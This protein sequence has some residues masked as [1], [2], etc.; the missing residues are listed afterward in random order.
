M[1]SWFRG[2]KTN[3]EKSF[4]IRC[5]T[6]FRSMIEEQHKFSDCDRFE[7]FVTQNTSEKIFH[8]T[9]HINYCSIIQ[10]GYIKGGINE[11]STWGTDSSFFCNLGCVCLINNKS[12]YRVDLS[13]EEGL[14]YY[15]KFPFAD[16][17]FISRYCKDKVV[18]LIL[19]DEISQDLISWQTWKDEEKLRERVV[20]YY[21]AGYKGNLPLSLVEKALVLELNFQEETGVVRQLELA[22]LK[23]ADKLHK[24]L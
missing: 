14:T 19:K 24:S 18:Y 23:C 21:E 12:S 15:W 11:T 8:I 10:D 2:S 17:R 1:P 5:G 6:G 7:N 3:Y 16:A 9:R 22:R 4:E 13:S 20:P